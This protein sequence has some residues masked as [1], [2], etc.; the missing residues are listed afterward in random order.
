MTLQDLIEQFRSEV[1]D[2][3]PPFLWSDDEALLYAIDAQDMFVRIG[4]GIADVTVA[5]ADVGTPATRLEDLSLTAS[6]PYTSI[7]PYILRVRSGRLLTAGRDVTFAQES[8]M[9]LVWVRDYG[10]TQGLSFDD[11]DTGQVTH[12]VLG[13]RDNHV[14]WVRVPDANDTCRLH[15]F[16]L[17]FPRIVKQEDDLE[18]ADHHHLHLTKWMKHLAY[19]KQDAETRDDK[20]SAT[21]EAAFR[22]YAETARKELERQRY[23]PRAVQYRGI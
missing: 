7:S 4:G 20:Q 11:S 6:N 8:D 23:R 19:A 3:A 21:F 13:V 2:E 22:Q 17:P 15:V 1:S 14:R 9:Q 10:W 16:R 18:I 12:G 5:A